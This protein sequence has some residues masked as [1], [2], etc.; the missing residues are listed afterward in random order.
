MDL[1]AAVIKEK[2]PFKN[3]EKNKIE[4]KFRGT[5][6]SIKALKGHFS[7][8]EEDVVFRITPENN[9]IKLNLSDRE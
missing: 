9:S 3:I 2:L 6:Y 5:D 4:C 8:P 7:G 1:T